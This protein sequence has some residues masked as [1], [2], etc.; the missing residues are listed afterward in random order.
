MVDLFAM[1]ISA[2]IVFLVVN[3]WDLR[4]E[5]DEIKLQ[6]VDGKQVDGKQSDGKQV[7]GKQSD[8]KQVYEVR[9]LNTRRYAFDQWLSIIVGGAIV[10]VYAGLLAHKWVGW[11]PWLR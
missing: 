11:F 1:L 3:V 5:R 9:F 10:L 8:G 7:D 2:V 6:Q 4:R